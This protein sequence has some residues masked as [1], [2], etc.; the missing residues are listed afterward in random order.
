MAFLQVVDVG[1]WT[2]PIIGDDELICEEHELAR[3]GPG[4]WMQSRDSGPVV[5]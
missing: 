3:C 2:C 5:R 1:D 4:N